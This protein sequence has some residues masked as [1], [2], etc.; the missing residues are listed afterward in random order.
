M[1]QR[2]D[3]SVEDTGTY[4]LEVSSLLAH[5]LVVADD[6]VHGEEDGLGVFEDRQRHGGGGC[7][8]VGRVVG[9]NR[10][11]CVGNVPPMGSNLGS[12]SQ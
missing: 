11:E 10:G 5:P 6:G 7:F 12:R 4:P 1:V 9:V 3:W 8:D 2:V